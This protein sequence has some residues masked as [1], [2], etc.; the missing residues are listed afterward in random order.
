MVQFPHHHRVH[1]SDPAL[2]LK[3]C[4]AE[5]E[6]LVRE[7]AAVHSKW[8]SMY[9]IAARAEAAVSCIKRKGW[10]DSKLCRAPDDR[11]SPQKIIDEYNHLH[12]LR[13]DLVARCGQLKRRRTLLM[14]ALKVSAA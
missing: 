9:R 12:Y 5:L 1:S 4:T 6:P 8:R 2:E 14:K 3:R 7:L 10:S 11:A 13:L